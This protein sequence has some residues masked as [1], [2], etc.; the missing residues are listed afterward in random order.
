MVLWKW[1]HKTSGQLLN[2]NKTDKSDKLMISAVSFKCGNND[3]IL[4]FQLTKFFAIWRRKTFTYK[5]IFL[6]KES[7]NLH[8]K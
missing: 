3:E 6:K 5:K 1:R 4:S 2:Q 8:P 7:L